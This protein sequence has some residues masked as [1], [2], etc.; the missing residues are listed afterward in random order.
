MSIEIMKLR[1][2]S[3][4]VVAIGLLVLLYFAYAN[5]TSIQNSRETAYPS[6]KE[7][8][9]QTESIFVEQ[10]A[11][12]TVLP[13]TDLSD[14]GTKANESAIQW[15]PDDQAQKEEVLRWKAER[16][17]FDMLASDL[18]GAPDYRTYPRDVLEKLG[19]AGDLRALHTLARLPISPQ[20]RQ[21]VLTKAAVHGS[22]F[23]LFQLSNNVS[24]E[25]GR[26]DNPSESR[27]RQVLVDALAYAEVARVRG[28]GKSTVDSK[29][30]QIQDFLQQTP[31]EAD[32]K[33]LEKRIND[34]YRNLEDQRKQLGLSE[35]DNSTHPLVEAF[36]RFVQQQSSPE[37]DPHR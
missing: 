8:V 9:D 5:R 26:E 20:E 35:F 6:V 18:N 11:N 31:T 13:T 32:V 3:V 10:V 14:T 2:V 30:Q 24:S 23:A 34:I 17:W 4:S 19:E 15:D 25:L 1:T 28:E 27:K 16:G 29:A 12:S 33:L 22:T 37:S 21:N 7:G 36:E